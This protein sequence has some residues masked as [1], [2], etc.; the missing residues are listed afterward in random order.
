MI[1]N[2]ALERR[3]NSASERVSK[4]LSDRLQQRGVDSQVFNIVDAGIPLFDITLQKVPLAVQVMVN[5]FREA[6]LHIWLTPLYHGSMTGVMKNCLDW[7][8]ISSKEPVPYLTGKLVGLVCWADGVQAMQGI[9]AMDPVARSLRA[10]TLPYSLP[11]Q[12][13]Y[14]FD[15]EGKVSAQYEQRFDLL[16]NLLV[17]G[18]AR[19]QVQAETTKST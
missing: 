14:L 5:Q 4:F 3:S 18:P 1:F 7:L 2:G 17:E 19:P 8:E 9:N 12:R 16:L 6:D 15:E 10:W 13:P 11:I